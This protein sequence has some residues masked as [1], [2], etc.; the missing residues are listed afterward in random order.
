MSLLLERCQQ[1]HALLYR[2]SE[3][4]YL[5]N[6]TPTI[7]LRE[8]SHGNEKKSESSSDSSSIWS[9]NMLNR[10]LI[11]PGTKWC[12]QGSV[13]ESISDIGYH[14]EADSCCR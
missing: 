4:Y 5:K 9:L 10:I 3:M 12:G 14:A 13:A 8:R 2:N 11:F 1:V 6:P 7:K